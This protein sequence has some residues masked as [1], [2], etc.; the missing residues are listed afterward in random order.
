MSHPYLV[1]FVH[2]EIYYSVVNLFFL[3]VDCNP[4]S[5]TPNRCGPDYGRCNKDVREEA[6][7]CNTENGWCGNSDA[8]KNAQIGDEYDWVS[9]S[10]CPGTLLILLLFIRH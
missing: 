9:S 4:I 3:V 8:H 1:L 10:A 5:N 6:E 2:L 7:Y